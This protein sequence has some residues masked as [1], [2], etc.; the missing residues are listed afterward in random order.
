MKYLNS[1]FSTEYTSGCRTQSF[2]KFNREKK[3]LKVILRNF[4]TKIS[5]L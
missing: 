4:K 1:S 3:V 2:F 5:E